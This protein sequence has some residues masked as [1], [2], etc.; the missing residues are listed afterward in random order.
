MNTTSITPQNET[1]LQVKVLRKPLEKLLFCV[2]EPANLGVTLNR[3]LFD[4]LA[5]GGTMVADEYEN[6]NALLD[7]VLACTAT[8]REVQAGSTVIIAEA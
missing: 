4:Y 3:L 1:K 2:S 8:K 7:F 6:L 5:K